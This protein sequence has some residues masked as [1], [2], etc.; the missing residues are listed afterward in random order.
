MDV[1]DAKKLNALDES[2]KLKN[3]LAE[4]VLVLRLSKRCW[5][6]TFDARGE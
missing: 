3:L 5:Q 4:S 6:K 1:S 2:R